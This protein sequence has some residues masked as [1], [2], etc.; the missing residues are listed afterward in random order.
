MNKYSELTRQPE[1]LK[2]AI[3]A[4]LSTEDG[5]GIVTLYTSKQ[6]KDKFNEYCQ[7]C[8]IQSYIDLLRKNLTSTIDRFG[9]NKWKQLK[10]LSP[11]LTDQHDIFTIVS[12][13][14][15]GFSCDK[16]FRETIIGMITIIIAGYADQVRFYQLIDF[17]TIKGR[18][19]TRK[20]VILAQYCYA[21]ADSVRRI[22]SFFTRDEDKKI[23]LLLKAEEELVATEEPLDQKVKRQRRE[24]A[25][26]L[27]DL[28][29]LREDYVRT[30]ER[31]SK[32]QKEFEISKKLLYKQ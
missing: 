17:C 31:A 4:R 32:L 16:P 28:E 5:A 12:N 29:K 14:T 13:Y 2:K 24:Y 22:E 15:T 7:L 6:F 11:D 3:N 23:L 19:M 10:V 8:F 30:A 9:S 18:P 20:P 25:K 26:V 21:R 1:E 27:D